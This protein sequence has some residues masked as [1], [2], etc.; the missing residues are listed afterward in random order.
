MAGADGYLPGE[1]SDGGA[2]GGPNGYLD[3]D[4][5]GNRRGT[6]ARRGRG[7]PPKTAQRGTAS[8]GK[9]I[10]FKQA[11]LEDFALNK[12]QTRGKYMKETV[13]KSDEEDDPRD[14]TLTGEDK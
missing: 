12:K 7:R 11:S 13:D 6:P 5:V 9:H 3:T 1:D 14:R 2:D 4:S 8:L 10:Q